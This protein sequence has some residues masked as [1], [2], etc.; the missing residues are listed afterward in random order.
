V[1][2]WKD[3]WIKTSD[4]QWFIRPLE[5]AIMLLVPYLDALRWVSIAVLLVGIAVT[6]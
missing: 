1:F 2:R 4:R 3:Y 6:I 5:T